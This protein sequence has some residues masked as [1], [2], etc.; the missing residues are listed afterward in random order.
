[1]HTKGLKVWLH[2][3]EE[4]AFHQSGIFVN[5]QI[6]KSRWKQFCSPGF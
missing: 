5:E 2:I 3:Q 1:M 4:T 6:V